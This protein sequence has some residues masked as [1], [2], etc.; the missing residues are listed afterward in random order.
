[1]STTPDM[2]NAGKM[3]VVVGCGNKGNGC[4]QALRDFGARFI[5]GEMNSINAL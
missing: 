2:M 1:M 5:I 4:A 3:A